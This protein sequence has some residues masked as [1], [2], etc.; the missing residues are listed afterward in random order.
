VGEDDERFVAVAP[1]RRLRAACRLPSGG[2]AAQLPANASLRSTLWRL[3]NQ[4]DQPLVA[5]SAGQLALA[6][7]VRVD[8]REALTWSRAV[9]VDT[10]GTLPQVGRGRPVR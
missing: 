9:L 10:A 5:V 7:S 4:D 8:Y 3:P 1:H 6:D 2:A